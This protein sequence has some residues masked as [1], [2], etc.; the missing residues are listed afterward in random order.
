MNRVDV[1]RELLQPVHDQF[2]A[3]RGFLC[4]FV[5]KFITKY[6]KNWKNP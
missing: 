2:G 5:L 3:L 6:F 1:I 4:D